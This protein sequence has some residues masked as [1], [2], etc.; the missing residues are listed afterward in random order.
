MNAKD[1][2]N[3]FFGANVFPKDI[4]QNFDISHASLSHDQAKDEIKN[5]RAKGYAVK[6]KKYSDFTAYMAAKEKQG[7]E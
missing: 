5:F 7:K 2:V 1:F 4:V 6:S 3:R